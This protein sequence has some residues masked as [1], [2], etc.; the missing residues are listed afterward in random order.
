[1]I[2][3]VLKEETTGIR[4]ADVAAMLNY[5]FATY[6]SVVPTPD[7]PLMPIPVLL[8]TQNEVPVALG[9][10]QPIVLEKAR[11]SGVE[12]LIELEEE[13]RAPVA[14]GQQVG[15]M[16]VMAGDEVLQQIPI[17][18]AADVPALGV[19]GIFGRMMRF[20]CMR[21]TEK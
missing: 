6:A 16:T 7:Q 5:G 11:L 13:L 9:E 20:A 10:V 18:A 1:M 21:G 2:A 17:V 12:K 8:G 3:V 4:S 15:S 19:W 14:A